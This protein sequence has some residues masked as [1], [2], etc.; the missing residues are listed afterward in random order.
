MVHRVSKR[1]WESLMK[2]S[3][4]G[5]AILFM[6]SLADSVVA[7]GPLDRSV[8]DSDVAP[9]NPRSH[10]V[11]ATAIMT[12]RLFED[13]LEEKSDLPTLLFLRF[14]WLSSTSSA[15]GLDFVDFALFIIAISFTYGSHRVIPRVYG[16]WMYP[17][18]PLGHRIRRLHAQR[19][20]WKGMPPSHVILHSPLLN[21]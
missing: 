1:I 9:H 3:L 18:A 17:M 15:H 8:S 7:R 5:R 12:A 6:E 21:P 10:P 4:S 11:R 13:Y 14:S 20:A 16:I 19:P 2:V